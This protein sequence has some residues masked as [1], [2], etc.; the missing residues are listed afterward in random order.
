MAPKAMKSMK[1]GEAMTVTQSFQ[2]VAEK[3]GLKTKDVKAAVDAM[4]EVAVDEL[5]K[6]G[7]FKYGGILNMKL[8]SKPAT[9]ARKGINPFTKEPCVFKAKPASKTVRVLPL[10]KLKDSL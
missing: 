9:K 2:S 4:M 5:K 6:T 10:K 1:A 7:S 8:K 3:T